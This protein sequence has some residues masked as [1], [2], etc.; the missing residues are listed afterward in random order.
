MGSCLAEGLM[1]GPDSEFAGRVAYHDWEGFSDDRDECQRVV[2]SIHRVP[3][4]VALIMRNHGAITW[5]NGTTEALERH[6]AF[7]AACR[8]HLCDL[9]GSTFALDE[10]REEPKW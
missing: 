8:Q 9:A 4:C 6:L 1:V 5:G 7:D 3:G 2:A 10:L